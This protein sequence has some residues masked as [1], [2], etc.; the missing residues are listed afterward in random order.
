MTEE[1][2]SGADKEGKDTSENKSMKAWILAATIMTTLSGLL[3]GAQEFLG[4]WPT[5]AFIATLVLGL[6]AAG[7]S[8]VNKYVEA[9]TGKKISDNQVK[10]AALNFEASKNKPSTAKK[11]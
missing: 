10:I 8:A 6:L 4:Q 1:K 5:A 7:T 2:L 9:R 11:K 3:V